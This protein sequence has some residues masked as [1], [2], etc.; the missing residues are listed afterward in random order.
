MG[1]NY[2]HTVEPVLK[3]PCD[4]ENPSDDENPCDDENLCDDENPCDD[5]GPSSVLRALGQN[6]L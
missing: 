6:V 3:E 2:I 1:L 5:E 4:D